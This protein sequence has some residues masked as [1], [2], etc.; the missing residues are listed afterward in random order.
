MKILKGIYVKN[1]LL[2]KFKNG[3]WILS[4]GMDKL[5]LLG[6]GL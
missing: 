5:E 2:F 3:G 4:L 6:E 1:G